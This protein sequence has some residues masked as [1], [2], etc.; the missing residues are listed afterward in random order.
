MLEAKKKKF[1]SACLNL[2]LAAYGF[3]LLGCLPERDLAIVE[4]IYNEGYR[5]VI[6]N[7]IGVAFEQFARAK[8]YADSNNG[9][10]MASRIGIKVRDL[11]D[12]MDFDS[13]L[14]QAGVT[15]QRG[16]PEDA[17]SLYMQASAL[18]QKIADRQE[19]GPFRELWLGNAK[20]ISAAAALL[21]SM[22]ALSLYAF[23]RVPT[24]KART[25]NEAEAHLKKAGSEN[26]SLAG[27]LAEFLDI[28]EDVTNIMKKVLK[29][30]YTPQPRKFKDLHERV[31]Q[32][33]TKASELEGPAG[34]GLSDSCQKMGQWLDNLER[35]SQPSKRDF[36]IWS[37]LVAC[38][39]FAVIF[40]LILAANKVFKLGASAA[41]AIQTSVGLGLVAGFGL[42]A[43]KFRSLF[44]GGANSQ[45]STDHSS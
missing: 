19:S 1:D 6:N 10:I 34:M 25:A 33:L 35:Q 21:T 39:A 11:L 28:A 26:A 41:L 29:A 36:G 23:D 44:G 31:N 18:A 14:L 32:A 24:A 27:F 4:C 20:M 12:A 16:E 5:E 15:Y 8:K 42:G 13:T 45:D 17:G 2:R 3:A 38:V 40:A 22:T 9:V 43:V 30:T 37:G 7:N